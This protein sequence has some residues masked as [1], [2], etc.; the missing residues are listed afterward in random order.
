MK[1]Q[2]T[3]EV[4]VDP[5]IISALGSPAILSYLRDA[6]ANAGNWDV[7][8]DTL[9]LAIARCTYLCVEQYPTR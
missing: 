4:D 9:M 6:A 3:L 2:I 7:Y 1:F 8:H 5:S